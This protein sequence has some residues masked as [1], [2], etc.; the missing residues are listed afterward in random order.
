MASSPP[1]L[2]APTLPPDPN[3]PIKLIAAAQLALYAIHEELC[4]WAQ[5][6]AVC[7]GTDRMP[8]PS[9]TLATHTFTTSE[10]FISS[11][12]ARIV[13][14]ALWGQFTQEQ[15]EPQGTEPGK[16]PILVSLRKVKP[17]PQ[18]VD[19]SAGYICR[20]LADSR[21]SLTIYT[22]AGITGQGGYT[23]KVYIWFGWL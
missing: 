2:V 23:H 7:I 9:A 14:D 13:V 3:A 20:M 16:L 21:L 4:T 1:A 8:I 19:V 11:T 17:L 5:G 6:R 22:A 12:Q 10:M 15:D 18:P